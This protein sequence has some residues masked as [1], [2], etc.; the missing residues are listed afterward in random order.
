[1]SKKDMPVEQAKSTGMPDL[2]EPAEPTVTIAGAQEGT[3]DN[4]VLEG[5]G[6]YNKAEKLWRST[7]VLGHQGESFVINDLIQ[8]CDNVGYSYARKFCR[9]L[10]LCGILKKDGRMNIK[11]K[12][13]KDEK[14][15]PI[16]VEPAAYARQIG[17]LPNET[18]GEPT[19]R[20]L[21]K[22][23]GAALQKND[24]LRS[25]APNPEPE[26]QN[27]TTINPV[28]TSDDINTIGPVETSDPIETIGPVETSDPIETIGPVET[29]DPIKESDPI[30]PSSPTSRDTFDI[31]E[32]IA[33]PEPASLPP[34]AP[35]S[36]IIMQILGGY[37]ED[38][39]N[40]VQVLNFYVDKIW[41]DKN[42]ENMP[43][44]FLLLDAA[45]VSL[46]IYYHKITQAARDGIIN[47]LAVLPRVM[48]GTPKKRPTT[49]EMRR[50]HE[51]N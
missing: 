6:R 12:F 2:T 25:E 17:W 19:P 37:Y 29:S 16:F 43:E 34:S 4:P 47:P 8:V 20:V 18:P 33:K 42:I 9:Y 10:W 32:L 38:F 28:D 27:I 49:N 14:P 39:V 51:S 36:D 11:Y 40:K 45:R 24:P 3:K 46:Q 44:G 13:V 48:T 30:K 22:K 7:R 21:K 23:S 26:Q 5:G 1:M 50:K 15:S 31:N 41:K 35:G